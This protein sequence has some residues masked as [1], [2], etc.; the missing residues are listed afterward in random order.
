[1]SSLKEKTAKGLIWG[2]FSNGMVQ[3]LGADFGVILLKLLD[4]SDHGR[5]AALVVFSNLAAALQE[6]GFTAAL[7]NKRE[8]SHEEY[9]AV[10]CSSSQHRS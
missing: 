1:M 9:N 6:S 2:A 4:P 3:V 8:P 5:M 7:A 10:F